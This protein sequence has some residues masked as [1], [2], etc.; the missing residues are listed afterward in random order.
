MRILIAEDDRTSRAILTKLLENW[1]HEVVSTANGTEAWDLLGRKDAPQLA[2]LDWMMPE[3]DGIEVI[4]KVR[5]SD[6]GG[7]CYLILLT[8]LDT[9]AD[10]VRGL[11]SGADD[12]VT[13][14]YDQNELKA[15]VDVGVRMITL[16]NALQSHMDEL[17][18][19][20]D[21]IKALQGIIPIC[22]HCHAIRSDDESWERIESYI[23]NH[24]DAEFSHGLCPK[25]L[26]KYYPEE[27]DCAEE[28]TEPSV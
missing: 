20:L 26:D 8:G 13:K 25:C 18:G 1:G 23:E 22:M 2:I 19:A 4:Q 3:L 17:K 6:H 27:D 15:R 14:P 7:S 11:E 16:K 9:K 21:H 24:S 5:G 12:Y 10:I 28:A